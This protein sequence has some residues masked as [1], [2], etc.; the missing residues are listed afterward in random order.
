MAI[1]SVLILFL[2]LVV[3]FFLQIYGIEVPALP[4]GAWALLSVFAGSYTVSRGHWETG[5]Y[6]VWVNSSS[7]VA[8]TAYRYVDTSHWETTISY[9]EVQKP[10]FFSVLHGTD[11]YGW[12][13]YS[14]AAKFTGMK[15]VTYNGERYLAN[16]Y[17]IDYRP[18]RGGRVYAVKY[19]F[20]IKFVKEKRVGAK[21]VSS[22]YWQPYTAY[23][24]IDTSRWETRTGRHWV[25]T[26][27]T[28][29]SG[30]WQAYTEKQWVDTGY[31]EDS[32]VWVS[33]GYYAE[34]MHGRVTVQKS[35]EYVFTMPSLS[36]EVSVEE[37]S[38]Y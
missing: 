38:K 36:R 8:Y 22:G 26:S 23:R 7:V 2:Y 10:V 33:S 21:W 34:P 11:S 31:Y 37:S 17:V 18:A 9:V 6:R 29:S 3:G 19:V 28:V 13:V 14:F 20:L 35:P 12:S 32:R 5:Q 27:Y 25:D 24:T 15:Q 16:V 4:D 1:T 30:Y